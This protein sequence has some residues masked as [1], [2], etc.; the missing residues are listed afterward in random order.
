MGYADSVGDGLLADGYVTREECGR[1]ECPLPLGEG[2][3][4]EAPLFEPARTTAL[5]V[6]LRYTEVVRHREVGFKAVFG[7]CL[8]GRGVHVPSATRLTEGE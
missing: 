8:S 1:R 4:E 2:V 3:R 5:P 7:H 6:L